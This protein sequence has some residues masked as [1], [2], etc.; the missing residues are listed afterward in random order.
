MP[1]QPSRTF[2]TCVAMYGQERRCTAPGGEQQQGRGSRGHLETLG[3]VDE[4]LR[5]MG[6]TTLQ[7]S[8]RTPAR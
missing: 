5:T 8:I 4:E 7:A 6:K 1:R 3:S 2:D